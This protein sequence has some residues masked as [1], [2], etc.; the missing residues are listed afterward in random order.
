M[1]LMING[2]I[3]FQSRYNSKKT[4]RSNIQDEVSNLNSK[5]AGTFGNISTKV[6]KYSFDICNS[7]LQCI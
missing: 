5:K 7:V 4:R 2:N 1:F 3:S 6:L